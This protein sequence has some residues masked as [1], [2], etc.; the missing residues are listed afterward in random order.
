[1]VINQ[2]IKPES[3]NLSN[4]TPFFL[5]THPVGGRQSI[6]SVSDVSESDHGVQDELSSMAGTEDMQ[7][8]L[9]NTWF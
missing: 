6:S 2:S 7:V 8:M 4:S 5:P 9:G 3:F 1:M